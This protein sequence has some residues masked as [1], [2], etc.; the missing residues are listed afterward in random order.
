MRCFCSIFYGNVV[1]K[2]AE[3]VVVVYFVG[4][5]CFYSTLWL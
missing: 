3:N 4:L 2:L 1:V 5:T